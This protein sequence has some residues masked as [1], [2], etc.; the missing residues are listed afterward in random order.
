MFPNIAWVEWYVEPASLW[1]RRSSIVSPWPRAQEGQ[2]VGQEIL[3]RAIEE[4]GSY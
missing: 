2:S 3:D 1:M 4:A